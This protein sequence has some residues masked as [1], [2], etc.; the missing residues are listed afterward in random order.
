MRRILTKKPIICV[1]VFIKALEIIG[2]N[3]FQRI[4]PES[5][6]AAAFTRFDKQPV[7]LHT[8]LPDIQI[9]IYT[10]VTRAGL[11]VPIILKYHSGGV[12]VNQHATSVGLGW[13]LEAG[14]MISR[15]VYGLPDV[16]GYPRQYPMDLVDES[17]PGLGLEDI[18]T[19]LAAYDIWDDDD[20][21][22]CPEFIPQK[23]MDD[24]F[25]AINVL[26][27][28]DHQGI[29]QPKS[30]DALADFFYY[31][32]PT[33]SGKFIFDINGEVQT[34]PYQPHQIT[35][36]PGF[37]GA[38]KII[39]ENGNLFEYAEAATFHETPQFD[40]YANFREHWKVSKILTPYGEQILFNYSGESH[41]YQ[42]P[43]IPRDYT[44]TSSDKSCP[45]PVDQPVPVQTQM[46]ERRLNE[47]VF[48]L[49]RIAFV[50]SDTEGNEIAGEQYRKDLEGSTALRK[51]IVYN[52]HDQIVKEFTLDQTYFS[53][54][55]NDFADPDRYRLKLNSVTE[56][57]KQPYRFEYY[58]GD[59]IPHRLSQDQDYW[60]YYRGPTN[61][62]LPY[63]RVGDIVV[64]GSDRSINSELIKTG[65]IQ[66]ITHPTGGITQ[67]Y[68]NETV[69]QSLQQE[70]EY[71]VNATQVFSTK[72]THVFSI[73]DDANSNWKIYS[74]NH[75]GNEP[76]ELDGILETGFCF[77]QLLDENDDVVSSWTS[78]GV[79]EI[80]GLDQS[81]DYK[82]AIDQLDG[83]ACNCTF[84]MEGESEQNVEIIKPA[85][86]PGLRLDRVVIDPV[87]GPSLTTN[88]DYKDPATDELSRPTLLP[89]FWYLGEKGVIDY[90]DLNN[91]TH[92]AFLA[93][94]GSPSENFSTSGYEHVKQFV[95]GNGSTHY[96]FNTSSSGRQTAPIIH[97][98]FESPIA[99]R[100]SKVE[101]FNEEH[102]LLTKET[103]A[104]IFDE[105]LNARSAD[106]MPQQPALISMG[107]SFNHHGSR[108]VEPC[109]NGSAMFHLIETNFI[110][111]PNYWVKH[112]QSQ[113]TVYFYNGSMLTD[114][115]VNTTKY[116]Y[117]NDVHQLATRTETTSSKGEQLVTKVYYPDDIEH[118]E[119]VIE[120]GMMSLEHYSNVDLMK[121]ANQHRIATPVQTVSYKEN[122]QMGI[123]R[124]LY[125]QLEGDPIDQGYRVPAFLQLNGP[126]LVVPESILKVKGEG[127]L[128]PITSFSYDEFGFVTEVKPTQGIPTSYLWGYEHRLPIFRL[129][130]IAYQEIDQD[131]I[132]YADSLSNED[133]DPMSETQ[134]ISFQDSVRML[135]PEAMVTTFTYDPL[136]GTTSATDPAGSKMTYIYDE[137]HRLISV[138]D[139]EENL[140]ESYHYNYKPQNQ[141]IY[142]ELSVNLSHGDQHETNRWFEANPSGGS[143][144]FHYMWYQ[145][146][147]G[148]N[149]QAFAPSNSTTFQM[150]VECNVEAYV[151]VIVFDNLTGENVE[152]I[153]VSN[154]PCP[155]A[156]LSSSIVLNTQI[157]TS[158]NLSANAMGGSGK[159][160]YEWY[161]GVGSNYQFPGNPNGTQPN[162]LLTV[163]CN[164]QRWVRLVVTDAETGESVIKNTKYTM[165]ACGGPQPIE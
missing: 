16:E 91:F 48:D 33:V 74:Q 99:G 46:N 131:I 50:Y 139:S 102:L 39:D 92:C 93:R 127:E 120:G 17:F 89:K 87:D 65:S 132:F 115:V 73:P 126:G 5:P 84:W 41:T 129:E 47:V 147:N 125:T 116:Y 140:L 159:V 77:F 30:I 53:A 152:A 145:S 44:H 29:P 155:Y 12:K 124:T 97:L 72:G 60:G 82:I 163:P 123:S 86:V 105:S 90:N 157:G 19:S 55:T 52:L 68:F 118:Q 67:F 18:H 161:A 150:M 2:Q 58:G 76:G 138:V 62:L 107:I 104:Y 69:Y 165:G 8:G 154:N 79:S 112:D 128:E 15:E 113:N 26:G 64:E 45:L 54:K 32:S 63:T 75:C 148:I 111:I 78:S 36:D 71:T 122:V 22:P 66:T 94:S 23:K 70:I 136:I 121:S 88:Y 4:I 28:T 34:M 59:F 164:S 160:S 106:F 6:E 143:G 119:M 141:E 56:S 83:Q 1:V 20:G 85:Q 35:K 108:I 117:D 133:I 31:S 24:Y 151:K 21:M 153:E 40:P 49:G 11:E 95:E 134:F 100:P 109:I 9:P 142:P 61:G 149:Y 156:P 80:S 13:S 110:G 43:V 7:N 130:G 27:L 42:N 135:Y 144:D 158:F 98:T 51:I 14:G 81:K 3:D 38:F 146:L 103:H 96:T 57:G 37:G 162:F 101:V 25:Y 114:S 10:I 137:Y